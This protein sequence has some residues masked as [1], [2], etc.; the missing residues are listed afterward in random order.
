MNLAWGDAYAIM[1]VQTIAPVAVKAHAWL[2]HAEE[3]ALTAARR[4]T[5]S[6]FRAAACASIKVVMPGDL[7]TGA[8]GSCGQ[9]GKNKV[10]NG[11][12][13]GEPHQHV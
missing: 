12:S 8:I 5:A 6:T 4:N 3:A 13:E 7:G 11:Y 1:E 10:A 9:N 2:H